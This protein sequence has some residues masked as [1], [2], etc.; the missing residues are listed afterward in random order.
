MKNKSWWKSNFSWGVLLGG[1]GLAGLMVGLLIAGLILLRPSEFQTVGATPI[2]TLIAAPT[3]TPVISIPTAR[4][5][6]ATPTSSPSQQSSSSGPIQI[7]TYVQ[8]GDTGGAGLRLRSDPGVSST[9]LFLGME[10]EVYQVTKGPQQK[11]G[12]TWWF[13]VAPYDKNRSG[14]A[15]ADYLVVIQRP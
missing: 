12:Y 14:W 1:L 5:T 3:L 8:I 4:A 13:L 10:S 9:P 2:V 11:D 6:D 7:G 15:A